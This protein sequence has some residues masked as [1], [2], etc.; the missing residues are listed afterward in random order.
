M[1]RGAWKTV[2]HGVAE[3]RTRLS[4]FTFTFHFHAL[5]KE[6]ATHSSVL[7]W[8]IPGMGELGGLPSMRSSRVGHD[9]SDLAVAVAVTSIG[10]LGMF[11]G[12]L[13]INILC[14]FFQ[15][16]YLTLFCCCSVTK[17]CPILCNPMDCSTP[18]FSVLHYLLEFAQTHVH[19]VSDAIQPSHPL[20]PPFPPALNR[21]Q[22]L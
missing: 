7:T 20:S 1:D 15:L 13:S 21:S 2:V 8:R 17:S 19:W 16:S 12:E 18:G 11:F 10:Q 4:D 3:G 14:L 5:E 9:W 22:Q 6:M